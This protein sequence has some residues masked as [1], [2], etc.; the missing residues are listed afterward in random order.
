[1]G[2]RFD[3]D[4]V[5]IRPEPRRVV[6]GVPTQEILVVSS[7]PRST[8]GLFMEETERTFVPIQEWRSVDLYHQHRSQ[9]LLYFTLR[10]FFTLESPW[11]GPRWTCRQW[12]T[13][14]LISKV[15][16]QVRSLLGHKLPFTIIPLRKFRFRL[17]NLSV[18][19]LHTKGRDG[20]TLD[21]LW[22]TREEGYPTRVRGTE[23]QESHP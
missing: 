22:F 19:G 2:S 3:E 8:R 6:V 11:T 18:L 5:S 7:S 13:Y 1:M 21:F 10:G 20:L 15:E 14:S 16:R 12:P 9:P 17:S 23:L 4:R